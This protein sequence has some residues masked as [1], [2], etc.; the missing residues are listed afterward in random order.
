MKPEA[1]S[2]VA[3]QLSWVP[4][5]AALRPGGGGVPLPSKVFALSARVSPRTIHFQVL[6]K[7]PCSHLGR[8][9][10]SCNSR[11]ALKKCGLGTAQPRWNLNFVSFSTQASRT[12]ARC[13]RNSKYFLHP[14]LQRILDSITLKDNCY[15][16]SNRVNQFLNNLMASVFISPFLPP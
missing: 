5:P 14:Y 3:A 15:L 1:V 2:H 12:F 4:S 10:P 11:R 9:P 7:S 16:S 8:G 13:S 6:D